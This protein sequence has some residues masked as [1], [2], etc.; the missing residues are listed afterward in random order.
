MMVHVPPS[1]L[2]A[3]CVVHTGAKSWDT[4]LKQ[5]M[6]AAILRGWREGAAAVECASPHLDGR[7]GERSWGFANHDVTRPVFFVP[8]SAKKCLT[9]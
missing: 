7:V 1:E 4:L 9:C 5:D 2:G 6:A 3:R 8:C